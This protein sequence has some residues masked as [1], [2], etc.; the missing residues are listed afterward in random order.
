MPNIS[1]KQ[2]V[3]TFVSRSH[4]PN[5]LVWG[6]F[7]MYHKVAVVSL[8]KKKKKKEEDRVVWCC[9]VQVVNHLSSWLRSLYRASADTAVQTLAKP[10]TDLTKKH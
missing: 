8:E 2:N 6:E 9:G 1:N 10:T 4:F 3:I 5:A 7:Q